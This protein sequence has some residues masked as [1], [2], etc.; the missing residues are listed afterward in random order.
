MNEEAGDILVIFLFGGSIRFLSYF[1]TILMEVKLFR[2]RLGIET[3]RIDLV[4]GTIPVVKDLDHVSELVCNFV[5]PVGVKNCWVDDDVTSAK[6]RKTEF[7]CFFSLSFRR[8]L[9]FFHRG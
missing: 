4:Y 6:C 7:K 5:D 2:M 1:V 8:W 9:S 3:D